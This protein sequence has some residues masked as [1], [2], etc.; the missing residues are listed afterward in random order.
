[1]KKFGV[2]FDRTN[3]VI[4][5]IS[6]VVLGIIMLFIAFEVVERHI[7]NNTT[8]WLIPIGQFVNYFIV[9]AGAAWLLKQDGH[10][11]M[12]LVLNRLHP[13]N[14]RWLNIITSSA[15]AIMCLTM[16]W[17]GT[18]LVIEQWGIGWEKSELLDIP[19]APLYSVIP[20]SFLLL[21]IQF[22]RNINK[23]FRNRWI[24]S[25]K[26]TKIVLDIDI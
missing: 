25:E 3:Q 17:G 21:F 19:S 8:Y 13:K 22:L 10:V 1:M 11:R 7:F 6:A 5:V 15:A 26:D 4:M 23:L 20:V 2:I 9:F 24:P 18:I 14:Q 16:V 12:D